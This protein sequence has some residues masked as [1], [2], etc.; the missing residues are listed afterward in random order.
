MEG[1]KAKFTEADEKFIV[2]Q[3]SKAG[4][5]GGIIKSSTRLLLTRSSID[6][7]MTDLNFGYS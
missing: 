4:E 3:S 6:W 7:V 2:T 5:A 1:A